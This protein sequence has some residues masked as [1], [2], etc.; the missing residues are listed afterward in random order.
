MTGN[1]GAGGPAGP[2]DTLPL[3]LPPPG[4]PRH[5]RPG[6]AIN[7]RIRSLE[8]K[9]KLGLRVRG[10]EWSPTKKSD[11]ADKTYGLVQRLFYLSPALDKAI[12]S[13]EE[14][15]RQWPQDKPQKHRLEELYRTLQSEVKRRAPESKTATPKNNPHKSL[16]ASSLHGKYTLC[17]RTGAQPSVTPTLYTCTLSKSSLHQCIMEPIYVTAWTTCRNSKR[18]NYRNGSH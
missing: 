10:A 4:T 3:P 6:A 18:I 16:L 9:W 13:F 5:L 12:E 17:S 7:H 1:G 11:L 2:T 15:A 8:K 14:L